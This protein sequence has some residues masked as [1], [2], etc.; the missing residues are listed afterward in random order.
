MLY[1][2][3]PEKVEE[4]IFMPH[5]DNLVRLEVKSFLTE[6]ISEKKKI[7]SYSALCEYR[8]HLHELYDNTG[9]LD[10]IFDNR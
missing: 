2:M 8:T 4:Y 10:D 3:I 7:N 1:D 9:G 6:F 5:L